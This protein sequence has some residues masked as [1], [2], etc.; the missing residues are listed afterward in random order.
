MAANGAKYDIDAQAF[1]ARLKRVYDSWKASKS[2]EN[3]SGAD[4]IVIGAGETDDIDYKKSAA[5]HSWLFNYEFPETIIVLSASAVKILSSAK[6]VQIF[7]ASLSD[8]SGSP[9]P[10]EFITRTADVKKDFKPLVELMQKSHGGKSYGTLMKETPKGQWIDTWHSELQI[11][12][13]KPVD[14]TIGFA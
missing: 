1:V 3:W 9:V 13:L 12:E 6:K 2:E 4:S 7:K 8:L 14:V 11:A 5:I 10:V